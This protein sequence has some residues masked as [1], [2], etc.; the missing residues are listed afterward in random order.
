LYGVRRCPIFSFFPPPTPPRNAQTS[1]RVR[2]E[3][4]VRVGVSAGG[5]KY[6]PDN[7]VFSSPPLALLDPGASKLDSR[8]SKLRGDHSANRKIRASPS[9]RSASL[10][11]AH[12][13][14]YVCVCLCVRA[15]PHFH[16]REEASI[17]PD[18]LLRLLRAIQSTPA[19]CIRSPVCY[20]LRKPHR[21]FAEEISDKEKGRERRKRE[22]ERERERDGRVNYYDEIVARA[23]ARLRLRVIARAI[24]LLGRALLTI[25]RSMS[26]FLAATNLDSP[27]VFSAARV[28][29]VAAEDIN[30]AVCAPSS[31]S[32]ISRGAP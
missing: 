4:R 11:A 23:L 16:P 31:G 15:S 20:S 1:A 22:G 29:Y 18:T 28:V 10:C 6:R 17:H 13:H 14:V 2:I 3:T 24:A 8:F 9:P 19:R 12:V 7:G 32:S 5:F 26:L 27:S 25:R 21:L 30:C